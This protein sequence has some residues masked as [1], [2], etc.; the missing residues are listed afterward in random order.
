MVLKVD[1]TPIKFNVQ[2]GEWIV[3]NFTMLVITEN[4]NLCLLN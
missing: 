1:L 4:I 2:L 3:Q